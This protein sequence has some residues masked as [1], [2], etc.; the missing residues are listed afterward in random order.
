MVLVISVLALIVA[1]CSDSGDETGEGGA[2]ETASGMPSMDMGQSEGSTF[3]QAGDPSDADRTI[4]ITQLDSFAFE[5]PAIEVQMGE[6]VTFAVTNEGATAHEFV[7]GDEMLQQGHESEMQEM[8]GELMPDEPSAITVQ[9]G[10]TKS[11]T[12]TFTEAGSLQFGCHMAGHFAQGMV[13]TID[14]MA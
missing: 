3:G 14:V 12:W 7:L 4:E 9:P 8:G 6:T 1:A 11:L 2:T 5:P 10:E 13:G